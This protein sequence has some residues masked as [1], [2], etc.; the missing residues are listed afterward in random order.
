[1]KSWDLETPKAI[2][3]R[4]QPPKTVIFL[5]KHYSLLWV[6][7]CIPTELLRQ[8]SADWVYF[9][10]QHIFF[11][12]KFELV[13]VLF[14]P[15][16]LQLTY[17]LLSLSSSSNPLCSLQVLLSDNTTVI[18]VLA[19]VCKD[20]H[21]DLACT[22]IRIFCHY[23]RVLPIVNSCLAKSIKKEGTFHASTHINW[24]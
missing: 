5:K 13:Q 2:Y 8:P 6:H 1:M 15:P 16:F 21:A 10:R 7:S 14:L 17:P 12:C 18:E 19:R 23:N 20:H 9:A 24:L 11:E 3:N 4:A 22:L